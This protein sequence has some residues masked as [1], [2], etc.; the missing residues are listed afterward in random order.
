[1]TDVL[2]EIEHADVALSVEAARLREHPATRVMGALSELADQPPTFALTA[3]AGLAGLALG[4]PRLAQGALRGFAA[5]AVATAAK[6]AI[7]ATVVRTRPY[8]L[9]DEGRYQTGLSGEGT[10]G[11]PWHS[12]PSGHTANAVAVA[13]AGARAAPEQ[14]VPLALAA[15]A[16][17][18]VQV[19]RGAHHAL[20]VAAGALVGWLAEAAVNAAVSLATEAGP[21]SPRTGRRARRA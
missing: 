13:R 18:V 17:G 9:L 19:P 5:A 4:R 21:S 15:L 8:V 10:D 2:H 1:M 12:F 6:S 11:G 14:A 16:V 7:K 3:L 20:D